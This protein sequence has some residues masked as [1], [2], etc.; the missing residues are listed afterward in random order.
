MLAML[1]GLGMQVQFSVGKAF[2]SSSTPLAED[3]TG[4]L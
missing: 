3:I 4:M 2:N 1:T